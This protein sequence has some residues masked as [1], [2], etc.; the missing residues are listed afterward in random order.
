M[1]YITDALSNEKDITSPMTLVTPTLFYELVL[2]LA[3][4]QIFNA[5]TNSLSYNHSRSVGQRKRNVMNWRLL[6]GNKEAV[7]EFET[8]KNQGARQSKDN[9]SY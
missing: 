3:A 8:T 7:V 1:Q 2:H 5:G 9:A 6:T 4:F